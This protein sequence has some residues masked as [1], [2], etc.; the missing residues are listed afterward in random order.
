[1]LVV[2]AHT[3]KSGGI[4]LEKKSGREKLGLTNTPLALARNI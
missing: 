1:M 3:A 4:L 2:G